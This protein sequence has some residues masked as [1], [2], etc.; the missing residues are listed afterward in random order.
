LINYSAF[1]LVVAIGL[2][3]KVGLT[4]CNKITNKKIPHLLFAGEAEEAHK[5]PHCDYAQNAADAAAAAAASPVHGTRKMFNS[6]LLLLFFPNS[7]V[8][9]EQM[10][11]TSQ[12]TA[13]LT[14]S[15]RAEHC[16]PNCVEG[17]ITLKHKIEYFS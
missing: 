16:A 3:E 7:L 9:E 11:L 14:F 6:M 2:H 12:F 15:P 13:P 4:E 10:R 1:G 17:K 5:D 8:L